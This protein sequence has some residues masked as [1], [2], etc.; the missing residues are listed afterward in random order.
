MRLKIHR[1]HSSDI[2]PRVSSP[3]A[4]QYGG[5]WQCWKLES[6]KSVSGRSQGSNVGWQEPQLSLYHQKFSMHNTFSC[7]LHHSKVT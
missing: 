2:S 1:I 6:Q 7:F 3:V 5:K 4:E